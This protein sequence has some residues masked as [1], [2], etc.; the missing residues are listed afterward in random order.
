MIKLISPKHFIDGKRK[1]VQIFSMG[2]NVRPDLSRRQDGV[3]GKQMSCYLSVG[4]VLLNIAVLN[5]IEI[6]KGRI[7]LNNIKGVNCYKMYR[8][9]IGLMNNFRTCLGY[10]SLISSK[11]VHRQVLHCPIL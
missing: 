4:F 3:G 10:S 7:F 11:R 8:E 9:G 5:S 2:T 1:I 6:V